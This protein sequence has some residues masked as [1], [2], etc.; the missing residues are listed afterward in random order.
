MKRTN[1]G[2]INKFP[3]K[4]RKKNSIKMATPYYRALAT[5]SF[6]KEQLE[7]EQVA[8]KAME[9]CISKNRKKLDLYKG[10]LINSIRFHI[11]NHHSEYARYSITH[12]CKLSFTDI[13]HRK[14]RA[15]KRK[16]QTR[17]NRR[18]ETSP[19]RRSE[20]SKAYDQKEM[21]ELKTL[22]AQKD[23]EIEALSKLLDRS[24]N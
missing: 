23:E 24:P 13:I 3:Q 9:L 21:D 18:Q 8:C 22:L 2:K 1:E 15:T 4:S 7:Q 19:T 5:C 20:R 11:D 6:L 17:S 10:H 14:V 16:K 12:H